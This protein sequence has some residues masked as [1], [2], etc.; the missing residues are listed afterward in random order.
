MNRV[1]RIFGRTWTVLPVSTWSILSGGVLSWNIFTGS[2]ITWSVPSWDSQSGL[3]DM[4]WW[5]DETNTG[6]QQQVPSQDS[7][8]TPSLQA[9]IT[10]SVASTWTTSTWDISTWTTPPPTAPK[11]A[12]TSNKDTKDTQKLINNLFK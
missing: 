9:N 1:G 10:G 3:L 12:W 4:V 2:V 11:P 6:T 7:Y 5:G 8:V